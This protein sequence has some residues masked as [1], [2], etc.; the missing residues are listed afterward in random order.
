M[1]LRNILVRASEEVAKEMMSGNLDVE[2][3]GEV[4]YNVQTDD[5]ARVIGYDYSPA[6][7][8]VYYGCTCEFKEIKSF[9]KVEKE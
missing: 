5:Q 9:K 4:Y 7:G 8:D 3:T 1:A 2:Y 6:D